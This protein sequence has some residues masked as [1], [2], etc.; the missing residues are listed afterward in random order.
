M[1]IGVAGLLGINVEENFKDPF[2]ARNVRDFWNRWHITLSMY[3]RDVVFTPVSKA[4]TGWLGVKAAN[5]SAAISIAVVFVL[6]GIWHGF[7]W[8]YLAFGAAH[9]LGVVTTHYYTLWL[10]K[11][12]GRERFAKYNNNPWIRAASVAV[13]FIFVTATFF[14]FA[15]SFDDMQTILSSLRW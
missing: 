10:K 3:M 5:H 11:R 1:A 6:I 7:G 8:N 13:T 14:L 12:L 15:N 4:M 2:A 9:A